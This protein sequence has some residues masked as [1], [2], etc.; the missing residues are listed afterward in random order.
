MDLPNDAQQKADYISPNNPGDW[1]LLV[2]K[3]STLTTVVL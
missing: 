2:S 3:M 1:S